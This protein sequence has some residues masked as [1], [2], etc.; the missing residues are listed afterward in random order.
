LHPQPVHG[1]GQVGHHDA[2]TGLRALP[3]H[4]NLADSLVVKLPQPLVRDRAQPVVHHPLDA[5]APVEGGERQGNGVSRQRQP[6][7]QIDKGP[8]GDADIGAQA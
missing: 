7:G 4:Q 8:E 2:H 3:P 6:Q 5:L 1:V